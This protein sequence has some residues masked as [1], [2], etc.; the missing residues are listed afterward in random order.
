MKFCWY[1]I[2]LSAPVN[3]EL[4]ES[5]FEDLTTFVDALAAENAEFQVRIE[6]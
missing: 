2:S 3:A 4:Q 6:T 5:D 1:Y